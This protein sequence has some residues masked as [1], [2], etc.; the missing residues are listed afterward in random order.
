MESFFEWNA[1]ISEAY[2]LE[3]GISCKRKFTDEELE[4]AREKVRFVMQE[5]QDFNV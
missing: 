2:C 5:L 4:E 1:K 3:K